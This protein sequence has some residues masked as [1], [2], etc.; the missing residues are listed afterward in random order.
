MG[1]GRRRSHRLPRRL[2][3][4]RGGRAGGVRD[5]G[6]ALAARG[7]AV[8]PADVARDHRAQPSDR[9]HP[10]RAHRRREAA[11]ARDPGVHR[12]RDGRGDDSRRAARARLHLLPPG[13]RRRGAGGAHAAHAR[14]AD[15]R[16]D[17]ARVPRPRGDDGAAARPREEED[18]GRRDP[19]PRPARPP[20]AG[21]ARG[22]A[23]G[24]LPDLQRGLRRPR[25]AGRRG[26]AARPRARRA[27]ARRARGP[28][29]ARADAAARRAPRRALRRSRRPRAAR[30]PGP[31]ALG[32]G[33]DRRAA[34]RRSTAR[35]PSA[36]AGRT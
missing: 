16:R 5:R 13:A 7:D 30:R 21:P 24:R 36:A 2:R 20:A 3:P 33:G 32:R 12:G 15:H 35:S 34:A 4:R 10:A 1:A 28:R 17:R 14:R 8:E 25:R 29:P 9:P 11:A 31:V 6:R 19:L 26:G 23:R 27:D 22:R 18:Q